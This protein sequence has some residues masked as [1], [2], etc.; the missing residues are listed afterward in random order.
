MGVPGTEE[1]AHNEFLEVLISSGIFGAVLFFLLAGA[2]WKTVNRH[3][4]VS[5]G[6]VCSLIVAA[7][8][9]FVLHFAAIGLVA[10]AV[11]AGTTQLRVTSTGAS[12]TNR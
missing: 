4:H 6:V 12:V 2:T 1:Y 8:T 5:H 10:G 7:S 3:C 9:D 11:L